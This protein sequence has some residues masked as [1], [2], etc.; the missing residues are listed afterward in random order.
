MR[1]LLLGVG[2]V[3]FGA[4]GYEEQADSEPFREELYNLA[5]EVAARLGQGR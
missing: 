4:A 2:M 5:A 1:T 3:L